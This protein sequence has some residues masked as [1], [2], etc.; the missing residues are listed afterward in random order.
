MFSLRKS[1]LSAALL[2]CGLATS[3]WAQESAPGAN[4]Q[5]LLAIARE[6]NPEFASMRHEAQAATER[7]GPAGALPDPRVRVEWMDITQGDSQSPTLLP[8]NVGSVKY[9]LSQDLPWFGKRGLK[10]D[11]ARFEADSAQAKAQATWQELA[12]RV[13]TV[14]AQRHYLLGNQQL[15]QELLDLM[16][17]LEQVAKVRYAGGLSMQADAIRA[18]TEQTGMR[19]ELVGLQS[20]RVQ[21]DARLN[22]LLARQAD[23]PLAS[24]EGS[25]ALPPAA[26]LDANV[27]TQRARQANPALQSEAARIQAAQKGLDLSLRNRYP[28]FNL[29]LSPTQKQTGVAEWGVMLELNIPLQ[30]DSRR[31][32]EREAQSMLEAAK[33]RT[34]ALANQVASD[35]S[36]NI[37][38]LQSAQRTEELAS[39]SLL[40]QADVNFRSAL[41]SYENG[42][43]DFAVLLE[44]QRSLRQARQSQI[45]AQLEQQMRLAE[46]EKLIGE[47]L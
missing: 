37:V 10:S 25:R 28:D 31:A 20:E 18:Q 32:Q 8:G 38:A 6:R 40:P 9:T 15:T 30:Q 22:A 36:Q 12:A 35:L 34:E 27:L 16:V 42:K 2:A 1:C 26:L 47:D 23:A 17:Q 33:S 3:A 13:K 41:A 45:K 11:V 14:Q 5:G 19:T 21:A 43:L 46:I 39:T 29:S 7:V 24:P 4:L 44:A